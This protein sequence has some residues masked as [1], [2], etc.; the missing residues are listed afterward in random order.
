MLTNLYGKDREDA[1]AVI[2]DDNR[3]DRWLN[4]YETKKNMEINQ[5][6]GGSSSAGKHKMSGESYIKA[7][8]DQAVFKEE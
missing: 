1:V 2:D 3:F 8:Q 4:E 5:M 6:E 7:H